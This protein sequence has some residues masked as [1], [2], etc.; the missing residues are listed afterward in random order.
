MQDP[1]SLAHTPF[2]PKY[3]GLHVRATNRAVKVVLEVTIYLFLIE[4]T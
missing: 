1:P 4:Y 3:K 2:D